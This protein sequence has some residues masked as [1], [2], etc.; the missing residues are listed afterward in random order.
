MV[1]GKIIGNIPFVK[2]TVGY[3]TTVQN[4]IAVLDTG[5][6]GD[7]QITPEMAE[8]L[9]L[10][11]FGISSAK[12]SNGEIIKVATSIATA[13]MEGETHS[14]EVLISEGLLLVGIGFLSKFEHKAI[15]N[16]KN[17]I[18]EIGKAD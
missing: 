2:I 7:L 10:E 5:F 17:K 8:E 4:P 18:I 13:Y 12:I 6:T 11:T 15:V 1:Q 3:G 16:F 14:I 9:E